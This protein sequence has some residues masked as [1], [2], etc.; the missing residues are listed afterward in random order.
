PANGP[1]RN[2]ETGGIV[3]SPFLRGLVPSLFFFFPIPGYVYGKITGSIKQPDDLLQF[4]E[5]GMKDLSGYIELMLVVAQFINVFSLS[6]LDTSLA[7]DGAEFLQSSGL[8]GPLMF[9]LYMALAALLIIF[10][11]SGSAKWAIF[12]PI[13]IS[14]L[15][16]LGY[17]A[18]FI[19]LKY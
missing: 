19:Q 18:A 13:F 16:Q 2:Q 11:G 8:T 17:G 6:R 10:I 14:M 15:A 3:P 9:T 5:Q 1:L 4:M 12:A 7:I